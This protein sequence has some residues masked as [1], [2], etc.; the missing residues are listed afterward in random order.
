[1]TRAVEAPVAVVTGAGSGLGKGIARGIVDAGAT[2]IGLDIDP[3]ALETLE[4]ECPAGRM[5]R[6]RCDVTDE[7]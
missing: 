3:A 4:S 5:L 6:I 1:M 7:E 2:V